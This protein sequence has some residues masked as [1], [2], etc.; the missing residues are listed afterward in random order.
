MS[1]LLELFGQ[2]EQSQVNWQ[3]VLLEQQ[4]PYL[5]RKCVKTRKS[6][7]EIAI[8]TCSIAYGQHTEGM[9]ICPHRMLERQQIFF[10]ALHLLTNHE[11]G[12]QLHIVPEVSIPGGSVDYFLVS[13]KHNKVQDFVG[14]EIQT[15]DTTGSLWNE[16][17]KFILARGQAAILESH[18]S[19]G[20]NW[21]MTA[22]T[23]LVQLHHKIQ[24]FEH[25]GK[26]LALV[27][28]TPLETYM[29]QEFNFS[30]IG[31]AKPTDALQ[32]HTYKLA[33][34][35]IQLEQR[36]STNS[37]GLSKALGLQAEAKLELEIMKTQ[38]EAKLNPQNVLR[39]G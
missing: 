16:R 36:F 5:N 38:L 34:H 39:I 24:T 20:M 37:V 29:R 25:L 4:C 10:D 9:I 7:P 30:S 14:I 33:N 21:K 8:G 22:K 1:A 11:P 19:F 15:L 13:A 32:I 35:Q 6:S 31:N 12:N 23:I 3:T 17:Q 26:H 27:I 2:S 18:K 28:Q